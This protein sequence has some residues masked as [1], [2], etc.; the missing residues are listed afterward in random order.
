MVLHPRSGGLL[1]E[2][3]RT[4]RTICGPPRESVGQAVLRT[5]SYSREGGSHRLQDRPRP[6]GGVVPTNPRFCGHTGRQ[7]SASKVSTRAGLG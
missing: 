5:P 3:G 2:E 7:L 1:R 4:W 6:R